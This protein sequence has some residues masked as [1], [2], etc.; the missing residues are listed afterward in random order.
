MYMAI[1]QLVLKFILIIWIT[2][3]K[4]YNDEKGSR[5]CLYL[6]RPSAWQACCKKGHTEEEHAKS[7][8][9]MD[10]DDHDFFM[11]NKREA[12]KDY[13]ELLLHSSERD[14]IKAG[15]YESL[16]WVNGMRSTL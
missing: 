13:D 12:L 5:D 11:T 10:N 2:P 9:L 1:A 3:F 14:M 16:H 15:N 8:H 7:Y 4:I 6:C